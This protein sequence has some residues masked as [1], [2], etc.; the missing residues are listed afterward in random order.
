M[1][2]NTFEKEP[3]DN[4]GAKF[5]KLQTGKNV[6]RIIS[7]FESYGNHYIPA[8]RRS[9]ICTGSDTCEYCKDGDKV[10]IR[11]L[12]WVI[13]R[14]E[15]EVEGEIPI[16]LLDVGYSVFEQIVDYSKAEDYGFDTVPNYDITIEKSGAGLTTKYNVVPQ[17]SES[18]LTTEENDAVNALDPIEDILVS[19]KGKQLKRYEESKG[20][21]FNPADVPI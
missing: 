9:Y 16:K 1:K 14:N 4:E 18:D 5:L 10:K 13:D 6:V 20:E 11:Y 21:Y 12:L 19:R 7:E 3:R 15:P 17:R 2:F 8:E